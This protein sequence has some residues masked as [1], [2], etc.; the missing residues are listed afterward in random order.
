MI[1]RLLLALVTG[2]AA[3]AVAVAALPWWLLRRAPEPAEQEPEEPAGVAM[4]FT[5]DDVDRLLREAW[6]AVVACETTDS[7]THNEAVTPV[8]MR[9]SP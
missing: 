2:A 8:T 1:L 5:I 4:R 9:T 7:D 6:Q 3:G